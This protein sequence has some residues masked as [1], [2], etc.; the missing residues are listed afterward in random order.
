MKENLTDSIVKPVYIHIRYEG[1]ENVSCEVDL[2]KKGLYVRKNFKELSQI[3]R[4]L[5]LYAFGAIIKTKE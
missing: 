3:E 5:V 4:S 1:G 2:V